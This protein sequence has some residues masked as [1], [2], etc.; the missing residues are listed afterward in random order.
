MNIINTKNIID[1]IPNNVLLV[2]VTKNQLS[3]DIN[4][5]Y[6][7]G[8]NNFAE[9][10]LQSI[11]EKKDLYP[12]VNWHFIGR[13]QTNKVKDIVKNCSLIHS[14][15]SIKVIDKIN[16]EA[17][18]LNKI[19][20]C[21]I[22]F[23]IANESTKDGFETVQAHDIFNYAS[24]LSNIKLKGIMLMGPHTEDEKVIDEV[25][26]QGYQLQQTL[27]KD[28]PDC[29]EISMGMSNDYKLAITNHSTMLRIGSV[30]FNT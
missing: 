4:Q 9:N 22:Q 12:G 17:N 29:I 14:V 19:Q 11:I 18:K 27:V 25:F 15:S 3:D 13:I 1:T 23:N 26:N 5:L 16:N 7:L 30:L 2:V 24:T 10:K 8:L 21:L 6:A 20:P 28:F